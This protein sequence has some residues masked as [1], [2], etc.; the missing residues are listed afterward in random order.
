MPWCTGVQPSAKT[1]PTYENPPLSMNAYDVFI[2]PTAVSHCVGCNF[3]SP[4]KKHLVVAKTSLL[5][6]FEVIKKEFPPPDRLLHHKLKLVA[7][8]KLQGAVTD[9][10]TVRTVEAPQLDYL[11]VS[12]KI[13]KFSCIRWDPIKHAIQTVSLHYY[14]HI[15]QDMSLELVRKLNLIVDPILRSTVCLRHAN[16]LA[17]LNFFHIDDGDDEDDEKEDA[18]MPDDNTEVTEAAN[19][20]TG[21]ENATDGPKAEEDPTNSADT[22]GTSTLRQAIGNGPLFNPS[23]VIE[24][25]VLDEGI[26]EIIDFQFLDNYRRPTVAILLQQKRTWAGLLPLVK[27]NVVFR[28]LSLNLENQSSTTVLKIENLPYDIDRVI[29]LPRPMFGSLLVGCNELVHVDSGGIARRVAVNSYTEDITASMKGFLDQSHLNIKLEGCTFA[30]LPG[31]SKILVVL[32]SGDCYTLSFEMD[33]KA[34]KKM[35]VEP[36]ESESVSQMTMERP[37]EVATLDDNLIFVSSKTS[38]G[39]LIEVKNLVSATGSANGDGKKPPGTEENGSEAVTEEIQEDEDDAF[40]D[41]DESLKKDSLVTRKLEFHLHDKLTNNLPIS[42]FTLG[43]YSPKSY[44]ANLP[45]PHSEEVSIFATG[46]YNKLGHINVMTPTIQPV[47]KTALTFSQINRLWTLNN[48]YLITSDDPNNK[49]EIFDM[50]QSYARVNARYFVKNHLTVAMHELNNGEF[51]LQVTPKHVV[52]FTN[53]FKRVLTLRE[54]LKEF[55]GADII[56]S[57][58]DDGYLMLFFS[59]GELMIYTINTYNK[60]FVNIPLP[61]LLSETLITTGYI[62]NSRLLNPVTA[63]LGILVNRGQK[64]KR[65]ETEELQAKDKETESSKAPKSKIFVIVTGDNRIV[66]FNRF[67]NEKCFQLNS[68]EKLSDVLNL[69]FFDINGQDPDPFIKQVILN[70]FGDEYSKDEYLTILTVG[71]EIFSYKMFFDGINFSFVKETDQVITGAPSN[72]FP[73]GTSIER[74]MVYFSNFTGYTCIL[75]TGVIPYFITRERHSHLRIFRFSKIPIVSF[76]PFSDNKLQNGIIYLDT[77]KNA[78]IVEMP[79]SFSYSNNW[80][81][82]R[83]HI[84]ETVKSVAYHESSNTFVAGTFK[85]IPYNCLDVEGNPVVGLKPE[86]P[87]PLSFTSLVKLISPITWTV[88]DTVD[89][90]EDELVMDVKT[91]PLDSGSSNKRF[92]VRREFVLIGVAKLATEDLVANGGYK[93]L[94]IKDVIPEPGRPE[95]NHKFKELAHEDTKG[96]VTAMCDVTGRFLVSQGQ[97]IIVRDIKDNSA[98]AVA[99]LDLG[100]YVSEAKAFGNFVLFGDTLKSVWLTG[101]DAEPFRMIML[102]KDLHKFDVACAD[103][104]VKDEDLLIVVADANNVLHVLQYNPEDPSSLNGQRLIHKGSF[105]INY[106][107]TC[108]KCVPKFEQFGPNTGGQDQ[109]FQTIGSTVEGAMFCVF[110]VNESAYRRMYILQQQLT[111]KEFHACGLNPKLNRQYGA[112][113]VDGTTRPM[114]D[115]ELIRRFAKLNDDRKRALLQKVGF[116]SEVDVWRDLI[117]MEGV[118]SFL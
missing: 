27:D 20:S 32:K 16:L 40:Y 114:I 41:D 92:K 14:E 76:V 53:R 18:D 79:S 54:E 109:A 5:Q 72:A 59:T 21:T 89:Y 26:G 107:A 95:T 1:H 4:T 39:L 11:L 34:V 101:F 117:E 78:R 88:I 8:Y 71:G 45:N 6:V 22:N 110:P 62:T 68:A 23:Y 116:N 47:I 83:I 42:N 30:P 81:I 113:S 108:M 43:K 15:F 56:N 29:P 19:G 12:T 36:T 31:Q 100:V 10:K 55:E 63:D 91:M 44:I 57:V 80:P 112:T 93:L 37:G 87:S 61:K 97:K 106:S 66:V 82:R 115:C 118:M 105:N 13:A 50:T 64:R 67:H 102:G 35:T 103:F 104:V 84:G 98:V 90:G 17:F 69:G 70:D 24:A 77:K 85:E 96:A 94:E 111:D 51:I 33:G 46:G 73:Q 86:K 65:D 7:Q 3:I 99:F 25:S 60:T 75:V 28:V 49:S 9:L 48:K 2:E 74:R 58:F 38:D 52:L